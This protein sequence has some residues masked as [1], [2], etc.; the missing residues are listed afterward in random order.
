VVRYSVVDMA[1][2]YGLEGPGIESRCGGDIPHPSRPDLGPSNPA[3]HITGIG[4]LPGVKRPGRGVDH[5][6]LSGA[7][8]IKRVELYF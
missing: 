8:I 7:E 1:T 5:Q 4:S 3:S 2:C 6:P